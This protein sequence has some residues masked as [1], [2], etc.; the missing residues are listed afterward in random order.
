MRAYPGEG[1]VEGARPSLKTDLLRVI[2]HEGRKR[3]LAILLV[4]AAA[5]SLLLALVPVENQEHA[6]VLNKAGRY[7]HIHTTVSASYLIFGCG[8]LYNTRNMG[9]QP[10]GWV[11]SSS[12]LAEWSCGF[13]G[14]WL[15]NAS[16]LVG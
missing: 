15:M 13:P 12:V 14:Y 7:G 16:A 1:G 2:V 9:F 4:I 6:T 11:I 8:V 3:T 5:V 10:V